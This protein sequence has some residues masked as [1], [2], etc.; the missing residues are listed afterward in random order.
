MNKSLHFVIEDF[1]VTKWII[2]IF[3]TDFA[4]AGIFRYCL[5]IQQQQDNDKNRINLIHYIATINYASLYKLPAL[6]KWLDT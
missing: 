5:K 6:F 1:F 4:L 2:I 3:A